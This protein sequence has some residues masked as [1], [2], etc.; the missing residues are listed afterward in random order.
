M[1]LL[2]VRCVEG[3]AVDRGR[4]RRLVAGSLIEA[5]ALSPYLGYDVTA[6][7]VKEARRRGRPLRDVVLGHRLLG[8]RELG[9]VLSPA[10]LTGPRAT[11][12][13]LR[14]RVQRA[15]AYRAFRASLAEE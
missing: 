14:R 9:R 11:D 13:A 5:T 7:V 10:A 1:R 3:I 4:A 15:P 2:R 8:E 6:E 12:V